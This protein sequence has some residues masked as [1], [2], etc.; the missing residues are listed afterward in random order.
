MEQGSLASRRLVLVIDDDTRSA[1]L[2][3]RLL[4]QDGFD[5]EVAGDGGAALRRLE[6]APSPDAIVTDFRMPQADGMA[7]AQFARARSPAVPVL[8]VTGYPELVDEKQ[9]DPRPIVLTKPISYVELTDAL[10]DLAR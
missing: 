9:L 3:A 4:R 10:R 6:R 2:L 7:V 8:V 5:V 1:H